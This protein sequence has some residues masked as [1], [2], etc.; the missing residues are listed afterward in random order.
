MTTSKSEQKP[1]TITNGAYHYRILFGFLTFIF[2]SNG[3]GGSTNVAQDIFFGLLFGLIAFLL[4]ISRRVKFNETAIIRFY[5]KRQKITPF[6]KIVSIKRS[7]TK[8]NNVR[9][10]KVDYLDEDGLA[11]KF[12]FKEGTFQHG[13]TKEMIKKAEAINPKI[14]VWYHPYFDRPEEKGEKKG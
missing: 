10:W 6:E 7:R 3:I 11:K 4:H 1:T 2:I 5:G 9:L 14:V 12:R 8:V 13:S